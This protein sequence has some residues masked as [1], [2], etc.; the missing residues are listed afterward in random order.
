MTDVVT[1]MTDMA[2][3]QPKMSLAEAAKLLRP[4]FKDMYSSHWR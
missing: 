2:I 3:T 4:E 1:E